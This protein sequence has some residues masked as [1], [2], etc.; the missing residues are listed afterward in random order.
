[1]HLEDNKACYSLLKSKTINDPLRTFVESFETA[2]DGHREYFS[3]YNQLEGPNSVK[4]C[5]TKAYNE[6]QNLKF[7]GKSK[8]FTM[9]TCAQRHQ[10]CHNILA[11][12]ESRDVVAETK[13]ITDFIDG[14]QTPWLSA[15]IMMVLFDPVK[16]NTFHAA[17][18]F[19]A[20][21][22]QQL[23]KK[24]SDSDPFQIAALAGVGSPE[25]PNPLQQKQKKRKQEKDPKKKKTKKGEGFLSRTE[26]QQLKDAAKQDE[27]H[28]QCKAEAKEKAKV[29]AAAMKPE[30][31]TTSTA[32][33]ASIL[34]TGPQPLVR[35]AAEA[36]N[37]GS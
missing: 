19:I 5:I 17:S 10:P 21:E 22:H 24:P 23:T 31:A 3:I 7:N 11:D 4:S 1:M 8:N 33:P 29:S 14:L 35:A 6:M 16:Y 27:F 20:A 34:K 2:N 13:K 12:A 30:V 28:A 15:A 18:S 25:N 9:D 37:K 36:I 26:A 32:W